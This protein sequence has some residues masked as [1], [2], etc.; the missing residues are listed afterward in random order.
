MVPVVVVLLELA[1][2]NP[3]ANSSKRRTKAKNNIVQMC[4]FSQTFV[5]FLLK[6]RK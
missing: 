5:L 2:N 6:P 3:N 4:V 1:G